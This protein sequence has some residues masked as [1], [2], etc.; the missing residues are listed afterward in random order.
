MDGAVESLRGRG[1]QPPR[2]RRE[3]SPRKPWR[4]YDAKESALGAEHLREL[5]RQVMLRVIDTRW[6]EHLLEMDY[7]KDGIGLR[8]MGQRDPL[9]EYKAEAYDMFGGLVAAI[10]EDFLR[11][12]MRIQVVR[13]PPR[14]AAR[15]REGRR[16]LGADRADHLRRCVQQAAATAGVGGPSPDQMAAAGRRPVARRR[17]RPRRSSRTRKTPTPTSAATTRAPAAPA[18]STRSATG[19]ARSHPNGCLLCLASDVSVAEHPHGVAVGGVHVHFH[20]SQAQDQ[21]V[22]VLGLQV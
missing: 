9:V 1:R 12:I 17:R 14:R 22:D 15:R 2:D 10:N 4:K 20:L 8:A 3:L 5:E 21:L 19:Q 13:K 7:L 16:V 11:T 6:M 18:R